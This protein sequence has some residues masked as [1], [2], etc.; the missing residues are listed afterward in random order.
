[1]LPACAST[2][3]AIKLIEDLRCAELALGGYGVGGR[4]SIQL[5]QY[6]GGGARYGAHVATSA[7]HPARMHRYLPCLLTSING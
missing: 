2:T 4:P 5:A 1:V 6:P 7:E 3:S